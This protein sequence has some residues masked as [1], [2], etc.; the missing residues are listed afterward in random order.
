MAS[1]TC[2][3]QKLFLIFRTIFAH[4]MFSPCSAKRR[5]SDKDLCTCTALI[6]GVTDPLMK[7]FGS[8]PKS[9]DN[10]LTRLI[11]FLSNW[12][13]A[14]TFAVN[15]IGS[16]AFLW[17]LNKSYLSFAVP[18]TNS[19]KFLFTFITGQFLGEGKLTKKSTIGVLCIFWG[20]IL[21]IYD[22]VRK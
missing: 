22:N 9:I 19:L 13:F 8:D 16:V 11:P 21:Q 3:V 17:T 20:V 14:L 4:N 7:K 12:R 6:W 2:C 18:V 1:R 10:W 5:A 15:Q